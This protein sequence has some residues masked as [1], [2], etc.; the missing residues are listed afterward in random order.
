MPDP[1]LM[2]DPIGAPGCLTMSSI[3]FS[4]PFLMVEVLSTT[5]LF[6]VKII[7]DVLM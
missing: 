7:F 5:L 3:D 2:K 6:P 1:K 4:D